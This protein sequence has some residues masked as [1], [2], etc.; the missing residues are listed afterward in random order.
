MGAR[1]KLNEIHVMIALVGAAVLGLVT[2]SWVVFAIVLALLLAAKLHS[3]AIRTDK[4][5]R[6]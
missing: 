5:R 2:G 1:T 3:G 6:K 4:R